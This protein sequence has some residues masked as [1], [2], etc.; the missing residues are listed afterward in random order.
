M[1]P[2]HSQHVSKEKINI[3]K[4]QNN[5]QILFTAQACSR[6]ISRQGGAG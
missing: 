4:P 3:H 1:L 6:V 5:E 2:T